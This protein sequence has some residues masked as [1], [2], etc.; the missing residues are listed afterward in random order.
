MRLRQA[1]LRHWPLKAA[2]LALSLILWAVI[3]LEEPA[4]HL[5][6][7]R[8]DLALAPGDALVRPLPL[9]QALLTGPRRE[10]LKLAAAP[11]VIRAS[12]PA[13]PD[14][15]PGAGTRHLVIS[16]S[17]VEVPRDVEVT[18]QEIQPRD[19]EVVLDRREV[20]VVPVAVR[21]V[22]RPRS[23][24]ALDG[25]VRVAPPQVVVSGARSLLDD[26]DSVSTAPLELEGVA[27]A[28]RRSVP[29]DTTGYGVLQ[30]VPPAVTLSGKTTKP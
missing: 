16:P 13:V 7:I 26:L 11:L 9:V 20:K 1:A 5:E 2:A 25:P 22:V 24:Y 4:T 3:S 6:D 14:G 29:L 8:L 28:F 27:G 12:L 15:A 17:D 19:I 23:G 21:A 18:V 10:F 30:M